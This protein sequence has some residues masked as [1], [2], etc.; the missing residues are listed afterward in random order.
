MID[1]GNLARYATTHKRVNFAD[2]LYGS[3]SVHKRCEVGLDILLGVDDLPLGVGASLSEPLDVPLDHRLLHVELLSELLVDF[4]ERLDLII[5]ER[6]ET[7]ESLRLNVS[8][9]YSQERLEW[10]T[11]RLTV[12]NV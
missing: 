2:D 1:E 8:V 3:T 11:R 7:S 5:L 6:L 4:V 12:G 10:I 9:L